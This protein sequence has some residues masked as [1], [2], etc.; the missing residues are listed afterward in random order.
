MCAE[1]MS[2]VW[3]NVVVSGES[4]QSFS[5][6][7]CFAIMKVFHHDYS[8]KIWIYTTRK[9]GVYYLFLSKNKKRKI[10]DASMWH[11]IIMMA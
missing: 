10:I 1:Y 5:L 4:K 9:Q 8:F 2:K 7:F 11:S 3:L 6:F